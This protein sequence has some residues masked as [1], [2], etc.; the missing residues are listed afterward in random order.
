MSH[1]LDKMLFG[2]RSDHCMQRRREI[3]FVWR[4]DQ[5]MLTL[6]TG[7]GQT[8]WEYN[9][10]NTVCD[11]LSIYTVHNNTT[12]FPKPWE[13]YLLGGS[14]HSTVN[15]TIWNPQVQVRLEFWSSCFRMLWMGGKFWQKFM[16]NWQSRW[17]FKGIALGGQAMAAALIWLVFAAF[18]RWLTRRFC[19]STFHGFHLASGVRYVY[20]SQMKWKWISVHGWLPGTSGTNKVRPATQ[21]RPSPQWSK[22]VEASFFRDASVLGITSK[23]SAQA[24]NVHYRCWISL[25]LQKKLLFWCHNFW[26]EEKWYLLAKSLF[27]FFSFF[28]QFLPWLP[29]LAVTVLALWQIVVTGDR[30]GRD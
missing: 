24:G 6:E 17:S 15:W 11:L 12:P 13:C 8:V 9:T 29:G 25:C 28:N 3:F 10:C 22:G 7:E 5:I 14:Q 16:K 30:F 21:R 18:T 19:N 2:P 27:I 20:S 1:R 23:P 4:R 26:N